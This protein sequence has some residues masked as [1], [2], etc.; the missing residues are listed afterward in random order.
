MTSFAPLAFTLSSY[1][2]EK[3]KHHPPQTL[4]ICGEQCD[5]AYGRQGRDG[6]PSIME[7]FL[8]SNRTL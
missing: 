3:I 7:Y 1:K 2:N 4:D 6:S 5:N 8:E